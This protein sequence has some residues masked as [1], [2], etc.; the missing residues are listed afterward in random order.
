M[1]SGISWALAE[2]EHGRAI[3]LTLVLAFIFSLPTRSM[4]F[5]SGFR[6]LEAIWQCIK[7]HHI[8]KTIKAMERKIIILKC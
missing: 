1:T 4:V 7:K 5:F 2:W 6:N 8:V 3:C